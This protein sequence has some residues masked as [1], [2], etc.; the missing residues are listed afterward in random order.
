MKNGSVSREDA[1]VSSQEGIVCGIQEPLFSDRMSFGD[2][3]SDHEV[4]NTVYN[5]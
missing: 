3:D 5:I 2:S 1:E 4:S